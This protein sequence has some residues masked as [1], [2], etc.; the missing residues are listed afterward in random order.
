MADIWFRNNVFFIISKGCIFTD[1]DERLLN[2]I[3]KYFEPESNRYLDN[4]VVISDYMAPDM[5]AIE[6]K[7]LIENGNYHICLVVGVYNTADIT[8][9]PEELYAHRGMVNYY[10]SWDEVSKAFI[11]I[12]SKYGIVNEPIKK[13]PAGMSKASRPV[14]NVIDMDMAITEESMQE[15]AK[16]IAIQQEFDNINAPRKKS[17]KTKQ[18]G[19]SEARRQKYT[20][21]NNTPTIEYETMTR[22]AQREEIPNK[23][24][25]YDDDDDDPA[26]SRFNGIHID[27]KTKMPSLFR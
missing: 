6:K 18:S 19:I 8:Q 16:N 27:G 12:I 22:F 20:N 26:Y 21:I 15:I 2:D 7:L 3:L 4:S 11:D 24:Q 23:I 13:P 10:T 1:T 25:L 17:K 5:Q 14:K 9:A